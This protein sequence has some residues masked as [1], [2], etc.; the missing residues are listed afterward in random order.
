MKTAV[1]VLF[2]LLVT[3]FLFAGKPSEDGFALGGP[4]DFGFG[5]SLRNVQEAAIRRYFIE[6]LPTSIDVESVTCSGFTDSTLVATFHLSEGE[7]RQL[8]SELEATYLSRQNHS[9][10]ADFQKR[11]RMIGPPEYTTYIY[12]LPG[13]P[14]FDTRTVSVSIPKDTNKASTVV[15]EGGNY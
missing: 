10:V 14:V 1:T 2:L 4:C 5:K 12:Y 11:R 3:L 6:N 8:V 13:A 9:V 7:A 15:F